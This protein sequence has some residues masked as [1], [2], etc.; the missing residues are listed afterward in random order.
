MNDF[1]MQLPAWPT[2]RR[3]KAAVIMSVFILVASACIGLGINQ[4]ALQFN[5]RRQPITKESVAEAL[6][7]DRNFARTMRYQAQSKPCDNTFYGISIRYQTPFRPTTA[8]DKDACLTFVALHPTGGDSVVT[9]AKKTV[10]REEL[11]SQYANEFESV[12]TSVLAGTTF[13]TGKLWGTRHGL[14]A[15]IYVI[16]TGI[17]TSWVVTYSPSS[18]TTEK[19]VEGMVEH[20][21]LI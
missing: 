21:S 8:K 7:K 2:R 17:S 20:F 10:S 1:E 18:P 3:I 5:L 14:P 15:V 11:M 13:E 19:I 16:K 4:L 6:L 12:T 9:L